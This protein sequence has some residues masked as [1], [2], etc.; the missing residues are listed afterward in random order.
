[1]LTG[2]VLGGPTSTSVDITISDGTSIFTSFDTHFKTVRS[3]EDEILHLYNIWYKEKIWVPRLSSQGFPGIGSTVVCPLLITTEL[4]FFPAGIHLS[5]L[6]LFLASK[7]KWHVL[8]FWDEKL[9]FFGYER[10]PMILRVWKAY[11]ILFFAI[12]ILRPNESARLPV[13]CPF[14]FLQFCFY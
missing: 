2:L 4:S 6:T 7:T 1:M 11:S 12:S 5:V 14:H 9:N 13:K 8:D 10:A 3:W